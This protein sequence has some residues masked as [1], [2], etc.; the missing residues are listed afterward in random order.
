MVNPVRSTTLP[1]AAWPIP[2]FEQR[3]ETLDTSSAKD[4]GRPFDTFLPGPLRAAWVTVEGAIRRGVD[5]LVPEE[6]ST[7][8]GA[9]ITA[10]LDRAREAQRALVDEHAEFGS[11]DRFN[12]D[13]ARPW[14]TEAW[15]L[16]QVLH[17]RIILAMQ[18]GDWAR[19]DGI[20]R[21]LESYR[22]GDG[23]NGGIGLGGRFYDD[24][25]WI[26][27]AAMQ[28]YSATG[29]AKYLQHAERTFR[30]VQSGVH[31]DGGLYWKEDE[32]TG[33]H[34][35]SVAPGGELA[36][37]LFVATGERRYLEFA[38]QQADW[39]D[40]NLRME[41]DLYADNLSDTGTLDRSVYSYNQ[42]T[43][44]GLEVQLYRATGDDR[45]LQRAKRTA[46]AALDYLGRDDRLW[47]QAPVFN[48]IFFRNL[49]TLQAVAPDARYLQAL[50][51]YL[52]RVWTQARSPETGLF[53]RGGI[54]SYG[55]DG[56]GPT[57]D[58]GA[59]SQLYAIRALPP[60]QW[61]SLT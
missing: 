7:P 18:G 52:D 6:G 36:M 39:L 58:Q 15:P 21:E 14:R 17:G 4:F 30:M 46:T 34:T 38:R 29:D 22:V 49:L 44:I 61:A 56:A 47:Q 51:G 27:L 10:P 40:A 53:D 3:N 26:G 48:A 16:G 57:I 35:C 24:N 33:R 41:D 13:G 8:D 20:F 2:G 1:Q 19:V 54:G 50:D 43:P 11:Q 28:A 37:Q 60:A 25:E 55:T 42:G 5:A 32:R 23:F 59:L 9:G 12:A 31:P 45:H